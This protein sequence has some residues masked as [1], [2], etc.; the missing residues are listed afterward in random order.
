MFIYHLINNLPTLTTYRYDLNVAVK[1]YH[2]EFFSHNSFFSSIYDLT[3]TS[4]NYILQNIN[5]H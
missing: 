3:D 5:K 2:L 1:R 4:T